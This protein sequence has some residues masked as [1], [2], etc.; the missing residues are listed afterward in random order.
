[1]GEIVNKD[2]RVGDMVGVVGM[3]EIEGGTNIW[4]YRMSHIFEMVAQVQSLE[5]KF[6]HWGRLLYPLQT[7]FKS[8]TS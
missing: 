7:K 8:P 1:M 4:D 3:D 6:K 5:D 2:G